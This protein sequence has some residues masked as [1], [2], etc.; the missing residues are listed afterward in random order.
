MDLRTPHHHPI[1]RAAG[2][3]R[4]L[5]AQTELVANAEHTRFFGAAFCSLRF[6]EAMSAS[7]GTVGRE[8]N[9]WSSSVGLT[10]VLE[11]LHPGLNCA[12]RDGASGH[13]GSCVTRESL[14]IRNGMRPEAEIHLIVP[15]PIHAVLKARQELM[16]QKVRLPE[17]GESAPAPEKDPS[18]RWKRGQH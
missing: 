4:W 2:K 10:R 8:E 11:G 5:S 15:L 12:A 14:A 6:L 18:R 3:A 1:R 17:G 16:G 13:F 9:L 7:K